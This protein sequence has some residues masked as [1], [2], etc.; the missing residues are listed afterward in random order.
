MEILVDSFAIFGE[1]IRYVST[2]FK[3]NFKDIVQKVSI[4][5]LLRNEKKT[6]FH[7]F[8]HKVKIMPKFKLEFKF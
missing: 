5:G 8:L 4:E 7:N 3:I 1:I 6:F 2:F